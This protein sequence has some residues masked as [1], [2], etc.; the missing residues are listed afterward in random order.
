MATKKEKFVAGDKVTYADFLFY[1]E[2]TN[3]K[4]FSMELNHSWIG[5][6][7]SRVGSIREVTGIDHEWQKVAL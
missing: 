2:L 6:W 5:D 4:Y 3:L 7:R 1:Y